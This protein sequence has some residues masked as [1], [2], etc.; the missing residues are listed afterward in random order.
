LP[1]SATWITGTRKTA[2]QII[3]TGFDAVNQQ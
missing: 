2:V 3:S 1:A